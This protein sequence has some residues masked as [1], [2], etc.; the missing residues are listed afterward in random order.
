MEEE[1][2][3]ET[4]LESYLFRIAVALEESNRMNRQRQERPD[5]RNEMRSERNLWRIAEALEMHNHLYE[6]WVAGQRAWREEEK[7]LRDAA[8]SAA[9]SN[10]TL[11]TRL[12]DG[13]AMTSR[14]NEA[15]SSIQTGEVRLMV[16]NGQVAKIYAASLDEVM[17]QAKAGAMTEERGGSE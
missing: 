2:E 1:Q 13:V 16:I 17:E 14:I 9:R 4:R 11:N 6:H 3:K 5:P 8:S 7:G 10:A 12:I 15:I